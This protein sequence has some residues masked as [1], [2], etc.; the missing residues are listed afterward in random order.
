MKN[1]S[2]FVFVIFFLSFNGFSQDC[3]TQKSIS[4]DVIC[5]GQTASLILSSS[6][7]GVTY[8]LRDGT[9]NIPGQTLTGTG[10][11]L[12]FNVSPT[13]T[14]TYNVFVIE[15]DFSYTD[16]ATVTVNQIPDVIASIPIQTICSGSTISPI[17]LSGSLAGTNFNWT[18]SNTVL[19]TGLPTGDSGDISGSLTNNTTIPRIVTFTITPT[20]NGC[21]GTPI[22]ATVTVNPAIVITTSTTTLQRCSGISTSIS[23]IS[24]NISNTTYTWTR[25]NLINV[26]NIADNGS[27]LSLGIPINNTSVS[28]T[29]SFII[30]P[31]ANGCSGTPFNI[32]LIIDPK[33]NAIATPLSQNICSGESIQNIVITSDVIGTTFNWTRSNTSNVTGIP[34]TG[35]GDIILGNFTNI[36]LTNQTVTFTITPI[37]SNNCT[38]IN[39]TV[40]VLIYPTPYATITNGSQTICSGNAISTISFSGISSTLFNWTRDNT[41]NINGI[42]NTGSGNIN[43]I[44]TNITTS[45]QIVTFTIIPIRNNCN[46]LP[47]TT[48]VTVEPISLGG[49]VTISLPNALPV[50]R[51][52][53]LC[54]VGSGTVYL[55]GYYGNIVR[56]ETST[57]A[58]VI[59]TSIAN[60]NNTYNYSNIT[61]TTIFRAV[62]QNQPNCTIAYS[63]SAMVNIIPNIRPAPVKATPAIICN[64]DSS[65][66]TS[67]SNYA[68]SSVLATGG[69]FTNANPPGWSVGGCPNCLNASASNTIEGPWRLSATNGGTY[70]GID[71]T[72]SGK[73]AIVNGEF[74]SILYTPTF[75]TF[76]LT[77]ASLTFNH[78]Y[79]LLAGAWGK[80]EISVNNGAYITLAQFNGPSTLGPYNNFSPTSIDLNTYLGQPNLRIRFNYHGIGASSWT[81]DNIQIP[82][83]PLNLST[84]WVDTITGAVISNN[85]N[86]TVSPSVTTTYAVTSFLN[87][88]NS[89][90]TDGTTYVTVT[91]NPRPTA[92]IGEDQFVCYGGVAKINIEF[93]GTGPW[94]FTYFNGTTS[95]TL[96]NIISNPYL[97]TIPNVTTNRTY[98]IT[99]L[100]D[101]KCTANTSDITG[102]AIVTVLNG[103]KGLWTGLVSSDWFDCLNWSGGLPSSSIDAVIPT[104]ISTMPIIDPLNSPY[105]SAYSNIATVRDIIIANGASLWMSADSNLEVKR[106]WKNSGV[107]NPGL[108]TVTF[109]SNILNSVQTITAGT[110]LSERFYNLTLNCTNGSKGVSV[111]D[112]FELTVTNNLLLTSGDLRLVG[113]AQLI[114]NGIVSNPSGGTGNLLKDQQGTKSSFHYNYWCS[115]VNSNS[116]NYTLTKVLKD[117]TNSTLNP[118]N[119]SNISFGSSI[120][121]ADGS[122]SNP[123]KISTHWIYKYAANTNN[124][125][126]WQH[127][128]EN[129]LINIGE[130]FTMKGVTSTAL[131]TDSQNYVFKGK[132]NNG[133]INLNIALN[134]VYLVGNPYPSALDADAFIRDNIKDG[135]NA[136][137]NI[138]NGVIYYWDHFGG[139]SHYLGQYVG[140]YATYS[141]MGGVV[142]ISNDPL[143]NSIGATGTKIPKRFIPVGQGFFIQAVLD[144]NILSSSNNPNLISPI[145]GGTVQFKNSQ[146][147]FKI[148]SSAN[149]IFFR[150][151]NTIA[152]D[153]ID[154]RQK[155]R[156]SFEAYSGLKRQLLIGVDSNATNFFDL[157]YDAPLI[158]LNSDDMYW[159]LSNTKLV[160]QAIPDFN[161]TQN[162]PIG[163]KISTA[164]NS[165]IKIDELEN[166]DSSI[167]IYL[168]DNISGVYHDIKNQVFETN[169]PIGE[170]LDRFSLRFTNEVLNNDDIEEMNNGILI[171]TDSNNF[172]NIKNNTLNIIAETVYLYNILGQNVS[173]WDVEDEEQQ[174]IKIPVEQ[175]QSGTYI[176][177]IQTNKRLLSKKVIIQ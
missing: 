52:T 169:L 160:I 129:G 31:N 78:A 54:H 148:E 24:S 150:N 156:L 85:A 105:A 122:I 34:N 161:P 14:T 172:L 104:G 74:N 95:T 120:Y 11:N 146:R 162:I 50:I 116:A 26:T 165:K 64:G 20:L 94:R 136:E 115:P 5:S 135:G 30:T 107:F 81:V 66:L 62:I 114:Q 164:G 65:V 117:G 75:N 98:T 23:G 19:V 132:P 67:E 44:L 124:Y 55:S 149:S 110:K 123:I 174:S 2:L 158:D 79:N 4:D 12:T 133:D 69:T 137:T 61:Q 7:L 25:D 103:T 101:S 118:F 102:L 143:I 159:N 21:Q 56:W 100:N 140:G 3:S 125:F 96:S 121:Y 141:L 99:A 83:A 9:T 1:K 157:G 10:A 128:G 126:L 171:F 80:I 48:T 43:G 41:T 166:I 131:N 145:T 8:I 168:F 97:L 77:S 33:P 73:F 154:N 127:I 37:S 92:I 119:P 147:I 59:W 70:S 58:G 29:V 151:N 89:F 106:D 109:N 167:E 139:Q 35:S 134:Q 175:F 130:G 170:Y 15:C 86:M 163:I 144:S 177:K 153:E 27:G 22:T 138:F 112:G 36:T 93:T 113:E 57:N 18:R 28:Q 76:G 155:I 45:Q 46:G 51:T 42:A 60:T 142:A 82:D 111:A 16:L 152:N 32:T 72:S 91:V 173:K 17:M 108:G 39:I 90:G 53:T 49:A 176:V 47:V 71:Y 63:T 6:E 84:Q 38:G 87:G 13:I 40:T 68:T 88:C